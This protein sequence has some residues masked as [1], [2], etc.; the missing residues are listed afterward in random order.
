M[1]QI[2]FTNFISFA[3]IYF[4]KDSVSEM[5]EEWRPLMCPFDMSMNYAFDRF[6][7]FLPTILL[8]NGKSLNL[9][10][11]EFMDLWLNFSGKVYWEAVS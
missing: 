2:S 5:L 9:W 4:D 11:K 6:S 10:L 8:D 1:E 3:R 7:L